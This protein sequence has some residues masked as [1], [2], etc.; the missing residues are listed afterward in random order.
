MGRPKINDKIVHYKAQKA[1]NGTDGFYRL[2][3]YHISKLGYKWVDKTESVI[4]PTWKI[5]C[6]KN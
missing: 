3:F 4:F 2:T 5:E 6:A 1:P